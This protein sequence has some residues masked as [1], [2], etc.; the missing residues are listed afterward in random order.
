MWRELKTFPRKRV[1]RDPNDTI[2][3]SIILNVDIPED[4]NPNNAVLEKRFEII[5]NN[6]YL[7]FYRGFI[8]HDR[9]LDVMEQAI[10]TRV[11]LQARML[12]YL[13]TAAW[14]QQL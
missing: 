13:R 10:R 2:P 12:R 8:K 7:H 1:D 4:Q 14:A 11:F 5:E 9:T 3:T 6:T